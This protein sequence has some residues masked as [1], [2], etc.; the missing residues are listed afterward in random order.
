MIRSL[1]IVALMCMTSGKTAT[2]FNLT[3]PT[4]KRCCSPSNALIFF[5]LLPLWLVSSSVTSYSAGPDVDHV[6]LRQQR[7]RLRLGYQRGPRHP[8]RS[9]TVAGTTRLNAAAK[10]RR[11]KPLGVISF[12]I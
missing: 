6:D 9:S 3:A 7:S 10:P 4:S 11:K 12:R 8:L 5:L 1:T 2:A